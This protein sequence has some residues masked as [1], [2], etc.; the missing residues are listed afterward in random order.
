M[1]RKGPATRRD[2]HADPIY[3][4]VVVTQ[5]INKILQRGKRNTA[6][7]I[8]YDCMTIVNEKTASEPITAAQAGHRQRKA[9]T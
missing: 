6:E 4:S 7:R 2:V 8:V 9:T 1:P 5:L 3:R